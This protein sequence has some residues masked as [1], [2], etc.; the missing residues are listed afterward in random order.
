[1]T[2]QYYQSAGKRR[3]FFKRTARKLLYRDWLSHI[4][5]FLMAGA[6]YFGLMQFG[7]GVAAAFIML[8]NNEYLGLLWFSVFAV[9]ALYIMIPVV[10][11]IFNFEINALK[12]ERSRLP[13]VFFAFES[14]KMLVR[15]YKTALYAL[16]K[17][18][19]YF[20]PA[21]ALGVFNGRYYTQG[22]FG[23][24]LSVFGYDALFLLLETVF[25]ILIA[26]GV[27][28]SSKVFVGIY[29]TVERPE[30]TVTNCFFT[31]NMCC[32]SSKREMT[33]L[34]FSF[35]P[36]FVLSLFTFGFLFV[37][38][39]IPYMFLCITM[40]SKYLYTKEMVSKDISKVLYTAHN[41]NNVE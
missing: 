36:L 29:V 13:D 16:W 23:K 2:Q 6:V 11:G 9:I 26:V 27:I 37:M 15:S 17:S 40:F 28:L 31:A 24:T 32:A 19:L 4:F 1:M 35:L 12:N 5:A 25:V 14:S 33:K 22:I 41:D 30:D 34:V 3:R 18:F 21:V 39:T 8:G 20:I 7:S 10:Y 38:Y